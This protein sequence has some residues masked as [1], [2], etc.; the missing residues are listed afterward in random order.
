MKPL[1]ITI[2]ISNLLEEKERFLKDNSYQPQFQYG[3]VVAEE[4]LSKYGLPNEEVATFSLDLLQ[5]SLNTYNSYEDMLALEGSILDQ[6]TTEKIITTYLKDSS[7]SN[8]IEV[9]YLPRLVPRTAVNVF[10][11]KCVLKIRVPVSY[12]EHI[13]QSVLDH[14]VGT[15]IFRWV[16]EF[17][18]VWRDNRETYELRDHVETEEGLAVWHTM[19]THPVKYLWQPALYYYAVFLAQRYSF[20]EVFNRLKQ[21]VENPEYRWSLCVRVKRG[22]KDT[23]QLGGYTKDML[24]LQGAVKIAQWLFEHDLDSSSLYIGKVAVED[25][26]K[27]LSLITSQPLLPH[28]IATEK[29]KEQLLHS[30]TENG[31]LHI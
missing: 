14:E 16:N 13:I 4:Q 26:E 30:F 1:T 8:K 7:L 27:C 19:L 23:S 5:K 12:G 3:D 6:P 25:L 18:Q 11:E 29:Y 28:W 2:S 17:E 24:Y 15:H 20:V 10:E 9:Q 21:F 22:L 31:V